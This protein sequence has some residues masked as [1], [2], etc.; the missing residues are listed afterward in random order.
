M[1]VRAR[2]RPVALLLSL[3]PG[4]G[5]VYWGRELGG[6]GIFT[7][8]AVSGF[9]LLNG[10]FIYI[11]GGRGALIAVALTALVGAFLWSWISILRLTS[12]GRAQAR[13]QKRLGSLK[14]GMVA[15]LRGDVDAARVAFLACVESDPGDV[16]ALFRLG[17]ICAR[18]DDVRN[19][20]RWLRQASKHDLDDKWRWELERELEKLKGAPEALRTA[21]R[22]PP[23]PE[24]ALAEASERVAIGAIESRPKTLQPPAPS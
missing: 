20:R 13:E 5:H 6:L 22:P 18:S 16:E 24:I 14:E 1:S 7:L 9:S 8:F 17:V 15:Y 21:A 4:W 3:V 19:A 2:S 10:L 12:P 11:G 23:D